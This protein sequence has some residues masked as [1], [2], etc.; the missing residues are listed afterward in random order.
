MATLLRKGTVYKRN[1]RRFPKD[2]FDA[3]RLSKGTVIVEVLGKVEDADAIQF[4]IESDLSTEGS[5]QSLPS[6][7]ATEKYFKRVER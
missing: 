5:S 7:V 6:S 2:F 1:A 3:D 4:K